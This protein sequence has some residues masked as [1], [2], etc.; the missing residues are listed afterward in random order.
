VHRTLL[1]E[2]KYGKILPIIHPEHN[3]KDNK[4]IISISNSIEKFETGCDS[5]IV[6]EFIDPVFA[7]TSPKLG[8]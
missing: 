1:T 6:P 7:K 4:K 8:L 5:H 3:I 2:T